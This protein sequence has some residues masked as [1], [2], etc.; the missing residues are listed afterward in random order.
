[1]QWKR[2]RIVKQEGGGDNSLLHHWY[3][4]HRASYE[5]ESTIIDHLALFMT[6]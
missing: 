5:Q 4:R 3:I 1:M 2:R 6:F